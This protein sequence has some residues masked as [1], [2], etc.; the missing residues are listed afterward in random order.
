MNIASAYT[1]TEFLDE[2]LSR[3][4]YPGRG[5]ILGRD[6]LVYFITGRSENSRNRVL[7]RTPDGVR[8]EAYDPAR[9]TDPSL[10]IYN[11]VR[12][13]PGGFVVS[14]GAQTDDIR[15]ALMNTPNHVNSLMGDK[16]YGTIKGVAYGLSYE[17][18]PPLYTPR[19]SGYL[20]HAEDQYE[21]AIARG[22][23]TGK[24]VGCERRVWTYT[25][26]AR[27]IS[28][29][30]DDGDPPPSFPGAPI[31]VTDVPED[32]EETAELVWNALCRDTRVALYALAYDK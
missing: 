25:N 24:R 16:A 15:N 20:N 14:N 8:T 32:C 26:G 7:R 31:R 23:Y 9:L 10:V 6:K 13:V 22:F 1:F 30:D 11:A 2:Y 19:I 29:Y 18:D 28:T 4:R 3:R 5:I 17:P 27:F 21:L 12:R